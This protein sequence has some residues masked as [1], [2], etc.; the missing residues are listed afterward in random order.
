MTKPFLIDCKQT[1]SKDKT[2]NWMGTKRKGE[3][4]FGGALELGGPAIK[5]KMIATG[6]D[7]N[8]L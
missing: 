5:Y 2:D 7:R 6:G 1:Y 3:G 8:I 4:P